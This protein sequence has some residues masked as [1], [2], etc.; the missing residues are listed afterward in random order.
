MKFPY[1]NGGLALIVLI[2]RVGFNA[3]SQ[4]SAP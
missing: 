3:L 2:L 4:E 1:W